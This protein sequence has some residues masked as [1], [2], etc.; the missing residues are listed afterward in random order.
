MAERTKFTGYFV[1]SIILSAPS[2]QVFGSWAWGSL[3][4][5]SGWLEGLGLIDFVG[6]TVV[7]S[8]GGWAA[9]AG[10]IVLGPRLGK[11]TKDG[12]IKP[13]HDIIFPW[14]PWGIYSVAGLVRG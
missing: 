2:Y 9:L 3:H 12:K 11:Y 6:S 5:G 13:I 4:N 7:H 1:Y 14:L 8:V 10:A